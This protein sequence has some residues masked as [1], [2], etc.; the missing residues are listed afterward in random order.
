MPRKASRE[1]VRRIMAGFGRLGGKRRA[2]VLTKEQ[3]RE[4]ARKAATA[5]WGKKKT[6]QGGK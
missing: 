2:E 1:T 6:R 4:I 5:R 3:R